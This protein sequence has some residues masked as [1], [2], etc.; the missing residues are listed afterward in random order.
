[1]KGCCVIVDLDYTLVNVNTT[2]DFLRTFYYRKY[3]LFSKLLW[4][5]TLL[6]KI[7]SLDVYKQMLLILCIRGE[8]KQKLDELSKKYFKHIL[9]RKNE[10]INILLLNLLGGVKCKKILLTA[11]LGIIA[12]YFKGLGFDLVIG[13]NICYRNNKFYRIQD[14]YR[15]KHKVI[16]IFSKYFDRIIVIEDSPEP[17]YAKVEGIKVIKVL[18][19]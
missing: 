18:H 7:L 1:M 10:H 4:P 6:N 15:N 17:E 5:L 13:T 16:K 19:K 12:R 8:T 3:T 11:S 14:L 9:G 2:F